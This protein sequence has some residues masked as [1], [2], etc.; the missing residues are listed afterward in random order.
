M[1]VR[2]LSCHKTDRS[3]LSSR[4]R[5]I[6]ISECTCFLLGPPEGRN[7]YIDYLHVGCSM[8]S[9]DGPT[10]HRYLLLY[11]CRPGTFKG[12][13]F[14]NELLC[15]CLTGVRTKH[16]DRP[17]S[18]EERVIG[19]EAG[20]GQQVPERNG[21]QKGARSGRA[22]MPR[23]SGCKYHRVYEG[24][25]ADFPKAV[26]ANIW[27]RSLLCLIWTHCESQ[28]GVPREQTWKRAHT[29]QGVRLGR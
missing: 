19:G 15:A 8:S 6:F 22:T 26:L 5:Y 21:I 16:F 29:D 12:A 25:N 4:Q 10:L 7:Y 23:C 24:R 27:W 11:C 28:N 9:H 3:Q 20:A 18:I 13:L 14:L 1:W 2:L 17:R